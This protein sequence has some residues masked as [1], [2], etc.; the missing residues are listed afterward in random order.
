MLMRRV[1]VSVAV[2]A[3]A[4]LGTAGGSLTASAAPASPA[5]VSSYNWLNSVSC[6]SA[7]SCVAVGAEFS[8]EV[9]A[10]PLAERWNGKAWQTLTLKLP[11][12]DAGA[13]LYGV[14]CQA[15]VCVAVGEAFAKGPRTYGLA[16]IWDGAR[17]TAVQPPTPAGATVV[18]LL[19]V[20]CTA[21]GHCVATGS[22]EQRNGRYAALAETWNGKTWTAVTPPVPSGSTRA[23]LDGVSCTSASRCMAVG[24]SGSVAVG[25]TASVALT[26][27]WNGKAWKRV[28]APAPGKAPTL[29]SVSCA[30]S[31]KCVAVGNAPSVGVAVVT[32][33]AFADTW[34]G[35]RWTEATVTA[36]TKNATLSGVACTSASKCLAVGNAFSSGTFANDKAFAAT[37]TGTH[38]SL[39][40][41]PATPAADDSAFRAVTCLSATACTAVGNES[42]QT[43]EAPYSTAALWNGKTWQPVNPAR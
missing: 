40:K 27:Y 39:T 25:D 32:D 22:Y 14:S 9:G 24:Q 43:W 31:V 35:T 30:S 36:P 33:T 6:L 34:N 29:S 16:E 10:L 13:Q 4:V 26:D 17:W 11:A 28:A 7:K 38:W 20:S 19:A 41:T 15:G 21:A 2:I 23:F 8:A 3:A 12:G 5:P 18:E 37:L 1:F 42:L